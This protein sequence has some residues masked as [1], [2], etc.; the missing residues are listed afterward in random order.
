MNQKSHETR[1]ALSELA[2]VQALKEDH[3][4]ID[5]LSALSHT[6]PNPHATVYLVPVPFITC[7]HIHKKPK[8]IA[9][10]INFIRQLGISKLS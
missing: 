6:T 2:F 10:G 9:I 3:L 4:L 1:Y 7:L 5:N 8:F